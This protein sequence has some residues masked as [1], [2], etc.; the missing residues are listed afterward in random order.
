MTASSEIPA[1]LHG[2]IELLLRGSAGVSAPA[3]DPQRWQNLAPGVSGAPH[4]AQV[5][6]ASGAAQFEQN[7]PVAE[8]PHEGHRVVASD[9]VE[10]GGGGGEAMR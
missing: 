7:F 2:R 1:M 6:P 4:A 5:A 10:G 3:G 9:A 8:A